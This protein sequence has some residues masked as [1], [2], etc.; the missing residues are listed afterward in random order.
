MTQEK[1]DA[2][3]NKRWG[4]VIAAGGAGLR[5]GGPTP[6]QFLEFGGKTVLRHSLDL[7]LDFPEIEQ[8]A[9]VLPAADF[10]G[11]SRT[12]SSGERERLIVVPGGDS[13]QESVLNGLEALDPERVEIVAIHDAARPLTS[14]GVIRETFRLAGSG[15][16]AAACA[17]MRDTVK[18]AEGELITATVPREDLWLAQT[19]QTFPLGEILRAHRMA[20]DEGFEGTD[21]AALFERLGREVRLVRSDAGNL[22]ITEPGDLAFAEY[23]LGMTEKNME[24]RVGQGYDIHPL[25]AGRRLVLGGVEIPHGKGLVGHSDADVLAHAIT[26]ALLGALALGDLGRHFPD[27]D[28]SFKDAD[29]LLLVA[30]AAGLVAGRGFR[31]VNVDATV[32]AEKPR[33]APHVPGMCANIASVLGVEPGRVSIKATTHERLGSL[34]RGE[35]IAASAVAMICRA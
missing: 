1:K 2:G 23:R 28:E 25:A 11:Y 3:T 27:T 30:R 12:L 21:D 9:V 14:P 7:F 29:S 17:P 26:D 18:R 5:L 16:G 4:A 20:R 24:M 19:P 32:I 10:E 22:K 33:I 31:V 34:G 15:I 35:G 8:V 6:K 13:R